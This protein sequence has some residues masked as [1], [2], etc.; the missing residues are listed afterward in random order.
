MSYLSNEMAF[1]LFYYLTYEGAVP[2]LDAIKDERLRKGLEDQILNF[3]QT[4]S[5][6]LSKPHPVRSPR[7]QRE[8]FDASN[9]ID[10]KILKPMINPPPMHISQANIGESGT[11]ESLIITTAETFLV[12][13]VSA[14]LAC[15][16]NTLYA[17]FIYR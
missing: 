5:Q 6:L 4:P 11:G 13:E 12:F 8:F 2:N 16:I 14:L 3:G 1:N 17:E 10:F 9:T 15:R 7:R